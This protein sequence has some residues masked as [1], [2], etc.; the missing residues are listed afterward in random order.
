LGLPGTVLGVAPAGAT[1]PPGADAVV[2]LG[3]AAAVASGARPAGPVA[4][5]VSTPDGNGYWTV[6]AAGA[7]TAE[8]DAVSYGSLQGLA[9]SAPIVGMARTDDGGGYW[10][11][12]ADGGIFAF[13]DAVFHGS[14]GGHVL[15]APVVGMA[16]TTDGG[17]Y[18]LV[19]AD[20]GIFSF[21]DAVFHGSMG[22]RP[23]DEPMVGMAA[24]TDGGGYWTVASDGGIFSFGDAVFHGSMGGQV[25][26]E[27][28]VG[29]A[30]TTDGGGYWTLASDGGI[31][32]FGDAPFEGAGTG[33]S[34]EAPA[35]G[36]AV[37]PGGYWLAFSA[38]APV[39]SVLGQQE[40]LAILGYLP[41]EWTPSGFLWRWPSTPPSLRQMW[42]PGS[43]TVVL[44]GAIDAFEAHVGLPLDGAI[45]P[46][47][48]AA[49]QSAASDPT[50]GANPDGYSYG[51]ASEGRPETLTVWHNGVVVDVSD[52]NTGGPG[53]P[54]PEGTWPVYERLRAQIMTG[55]DPDGAHYADP[56]QYVAYF[57][58]S[59]AVHYIARAGYGWPQSL[60]CVELPLGPAAVVWPYLTYGTLVTVN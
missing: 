32:S 28:M 55:T 35:A 10:L 56:V 33:G 52:A 27:P 30:A 21:G 29:M 43:D 11:V 42:V 48:T 59:D 2:G 7:V 20:G 44:Q 37:R 57:H 58:G 19:A 39:G 9:L 14:M 4:G 47:E 53:A 46:A 17:G 3:T 23:L 31:F 54:T 49:L 5:I 60:G 1:A 45:S 40:L 16:A 38:T 18:W 25:L 22:G 26:D 12:G 34:I 36:M 8:G 50:A 24:T 13:G 41:V 6:S 51:V 15:A